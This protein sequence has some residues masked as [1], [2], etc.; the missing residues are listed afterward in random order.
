MTARESGEPTPAAMAA[1]R[2]LGDALADHKGARA[3]I[4]ATEAQMVLLAARAL[5][6]FAAAA[7]AAAM[8]RVTALTCVRMEGDR[9]VTAHDFK[10]DYMMF[11]THHRYCTR[12]GRAE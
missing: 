12:C 8:E 6:A 11:D 7:V 10:A 3:S 4:E 5:D 9:A 2:R 1:A